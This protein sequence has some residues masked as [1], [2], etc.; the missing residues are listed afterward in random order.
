[1][2]SLPINETQFQ[3]CVSSVFDLTYTSPDRTAATPLAQTGHAP[4]GLVTSGLPR[5]RTSNLRLRRA[6]FYP[7]ELE[8]HE[9]PITESSRVLDVRS[10]PCH[11]S[12]SSGIKPTGLDLNQ[13]KPGVS[14]QCSTGLSYQSLCP[15]PRL[16][17][18]MDG[19]A[20]TT[21][22]EPVADGVTIRLSHQRLPITVMFWLPVSVVLLSV[23][24]GISPT[25]LHHFVRTP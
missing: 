25:S 10:V 14:S 20:V 23:N 8:D 7:V 19:Q 12:H 17:W 9:Y 3:R 4:V 13:R 15:E 18:R 6:V 21:G 11:P 1:M 5:I 24:L 16:D 2:P 22:I